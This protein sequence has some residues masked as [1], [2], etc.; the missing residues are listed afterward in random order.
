MRGGP[1]GARRRA[2]RGPGRSSVVVAVVVVVVVVVI[3]VGGGA[4]GLGRRHLVGRLG[5]SWHRGRDRAWGR[6]RGPLGAG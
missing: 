4:L 2:G 3:V 1:A 5:R 6:I